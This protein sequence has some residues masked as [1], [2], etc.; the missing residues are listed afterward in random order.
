[1]QTYRASR[2]I[3]LIGF[4]IM[5]SM[6]GFFV[7]LV[8]RLAPMYIEYMGVVS[9][10]DQLKSEAGV[11]QKS[12]EQLRRSLMTK[13][14]AQYVDT[15]TVSPQTVQLERGEGGGVTLR[16]HYEKRVPFAYNVD[17]VGTFDKAVSL[18]GDR[19]Y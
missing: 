13:F 16:I 14:D 5:L 15:K 9:A 10:V 3:T 8:M 2:G 1:M 4:L 11:E 19:S 6:V 12:I 7:Y 18:S 17:F